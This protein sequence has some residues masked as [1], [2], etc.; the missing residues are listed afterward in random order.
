MPIIL[1]DYY[2]KINGDIPIGTEGDVPLDRV[3]RKE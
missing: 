3:W 1:P 2:G